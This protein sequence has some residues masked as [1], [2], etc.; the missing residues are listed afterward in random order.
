MTTTTTSTRDRSASSKKG[1]ITR[2]RNATIAAKTAR[3]VAKSASS[4]KGHETRR[5]NKE[6]AALAAA[7]PMLDRGGD[8]GMPAFAF[9]PAAPAVPAPAPV[10]GKRQG[11][12][13]RPAGEMNTRELWNARRLVGETLLPFL[14]NARGEIT[15]PE[16]ITQRLRDLITGAVRPAKAPRPPAKEETRR[17]RAEVADIV[18]RLIVHEGGS[19]IPATDVASLRGLLAA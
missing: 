1:H 5:A 6:R 7:A 15:L 13:A 19:T 17:A 4:K 12:P 11:R 3:A 10:L 18:S 2:R 14:Q 8:V 16:G 9:L